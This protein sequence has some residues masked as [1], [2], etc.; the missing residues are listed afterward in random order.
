MI[1][2]H[3]QRRIDTLIP[4]LKLDSQPIEHVSEFHFLGLTLDEHHSWKPHVQKVA[5]KTSRTIGILR[6]LK[7]I[8]PISVL[9]TLYNTLILPHFHYCILS[10]GFRMGRLKF[11]QKRAVRVM[12]GSRYNAHTDPLFKIQDSR[13]KSIYST[14]YRH[15]SYKTMEQCEKTNQNISWWVHVWRPSL[16]PYGRYH[17]GHQKMFGST[18]RIKVSRYDSNN[19]KKKKINAKGNKCGDNAIWRVD[20]YKQNK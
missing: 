10:W 4:D 17:K 14:M 11:L 20:Y 8:I 7:N 9:R 12:S 5:N 18:G 2:H 19:N 15:Q 16:R 1:F 13:F 3:Q 6:W